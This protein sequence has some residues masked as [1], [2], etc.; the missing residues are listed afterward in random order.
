MTIAKIEES[1]AGNPLRFA[2]LE[3]VATKELRRFHHHLTREFT[4]A[5][6]LYGNRQARRLPAP[7]RS[8]PSC[9]AR[10]V[11]LSGARNG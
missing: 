6:M 9:S 11:G 4:T 8:N 1:I 3:L 10:T 2:S 7:L 5:I